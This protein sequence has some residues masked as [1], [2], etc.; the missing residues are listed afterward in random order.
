VTP[1]AEMKSPT[2]NGRRRTRKTPA[3]KF[4]SMPLQATPMATPPAA[5]RAA[6]LVVSTPK[7]PRMATTRMTVSTAEMAES[8]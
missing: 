7:K 4:A 2:L 8:T 3:A 6:K 5:K 1:A